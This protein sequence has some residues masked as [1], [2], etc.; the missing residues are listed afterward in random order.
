MCVVH[1]DEKVIRSTPTITPAH[2]NKAPAALKLE[3]LQE[4]VRAAA[5]KDDE[6]LIE[7]SE[8]F[9]GKFGRT[10]TRSLTELGK[11]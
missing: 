2:T 5:P 11:W 10:V 1:P 9:I 8:R 3:Q 6:L 7:L 4:A